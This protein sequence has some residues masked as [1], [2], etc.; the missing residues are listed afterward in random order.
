MLNKAKMFDP[1]AETIDR[2]TEIIGFDRSAVYVFDYGADPLLSRG[3]TPR[4]SDGWTA[5]RAYLQDRS[6]A[7]REALRAVLK[8]VA[9]AWQYTH[10]LPDPTRVPP[11]GYTLDSF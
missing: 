9:I 2:F 10:D 5:V 3:Q 6:P 8:P 1:I 7:N 4:V 11:D